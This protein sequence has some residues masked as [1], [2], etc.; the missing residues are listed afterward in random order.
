MNLVALTLKSWQNQFLHKYYHELF[1]Q[2]CQ[3]LGS[4]KLVS[5]NYLYYIGIYE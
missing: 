1:F 3:A 2:R 4:N 5:V